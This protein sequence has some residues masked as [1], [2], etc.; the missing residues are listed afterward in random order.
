VI[1]RGKGRIV[2]E[3]D[4]MWSFIGKKA[5]RVWIWLAIDRENRQIVGFH[6]GGRG[7]EDARLLWESLPG[8]YRQCAVCYTDFWES[9]QGVIPKNRHRAVGK[10]TG[11][12]N[13]IESFNCTVRQRVS[14]MVRKTLSFPKSFKNLILS[15][16]YFIWNYN[17]QKRID[18]EL[19]NAV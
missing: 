18:L 5:V 10:E 1:K 8:V 14:R 13:H 6:V 12:T 19:I 2:I 7:R 17:T 9:Y 11:E 3:T 15:L 4:E 16:K